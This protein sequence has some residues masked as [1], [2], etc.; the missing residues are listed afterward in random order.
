M[1]ERTPEQ[2]AQR[3]RRK[4]K[5]RDWDI[6]VCVDMDDPDRRWSYH[7]PLTEAQETLGGLAAR[8]QCETCGEQFLTSGAR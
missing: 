3:E 6:A 4:L 1:S 7:Y 8:R 2:D 5:R